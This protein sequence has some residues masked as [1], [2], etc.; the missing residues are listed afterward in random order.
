MTMENERKTVWYLEPYVWLVISFPLTAVVAGIITIIFAVNSNDG[1]VTDDYYKR[2]LAINRVLERDQMA[3]QY[4]LQATLDIIRGNPF[5]KVMLTGNREF[6]YP[7]K[8]T[9]RFL[10]PTRKGLD[11]QLVLDRIDDGNYRGSAPA[12]VN[13]KW[14]VSIEAQDWRLLKEYTVR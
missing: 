10:H 14:Y 13:G 5:V 1:L 7:E 12:L 2:G 3:S 11:R 6:I 4:Q 8:I 9:V